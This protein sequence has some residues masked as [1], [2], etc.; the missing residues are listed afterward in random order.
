MPGRGPWPCP[1][2]NAIW[3][4]PAKPGNTLQ[5]GH[6]AAKTS[7]PPRYPLPRGETK[8]DPNNKNAGERSDNPSYGAANRIVSQSQRI[9]PLSPGWVLGS[10]AYV[11]FTGRGR[12]VGRRGSVLL[13]AG[14]PLTTRTGH[15]RTRPAFHRAGRKHDGRI[16]TDLTAPIA[17]C[18]SCRI[19]RR[20]ARGEAPRASPGYHAP[21]MWP[22]VVGRVSPRRGSSVV[23]ASR[24][25]AKALKIASTSW[26]VL[27]P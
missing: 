17:V 23:A 6:P 16:G 1:T 19:G 14:F 18:R 24:A 2:R 22:L 9:A 26:W 15:A 4:T 11:V 27:R 20:L 3:H 5:D 7:G 12:R 13:P 21:S 8:A 25:R 10:S